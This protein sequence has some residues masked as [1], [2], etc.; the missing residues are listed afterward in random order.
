MTIYLEDSKFLK[1]YNAY[2]Q[3]YDRDNNIQPKEKYGKLQHVSTHFTA[4]NAVQ[5]TTKNSTFFQNIYEIVFDDMRH[6]L[7]EHKPKEYAKIDWT[8]SAD[9]I[10]NY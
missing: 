6:Y 3:W 1:L 8:K 5:V 10:F 2:L 4:H 7:R 9:E